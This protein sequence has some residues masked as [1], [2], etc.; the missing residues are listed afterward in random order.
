MRLICPECAAQYE[1]DVS[2]IP[3]GGR[4]VQCSNCGHTWWQ[5][6]DGIRE[7]EPKPEQAP[8]DDIAEDVAEPAPQQAPEAAEERSSKPVMHENLEAED[9]AATLAA[10]AGAQGTVPDHPDRSLDDAVLDVLREEAHRET[11]A[12]VAEDPDRKSEA[13]DSKAEET[14]E[15]DVDPQKVKFTAEGVPIAPRPHN[16]KL[17]PDIDE[18]NSTLDGQDAAEDDDDDGDTEDGLARPKKRGFRVG[19]VLMLTVAAALVAVYVYAD[20]IGEKVPS[21]K[22]TLATF[23]EKV[24][25]GRIWLDQAALRASEAIKD[26]T[27]GE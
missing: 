2:V 16:S 15:S 4:D 3:E 13:D 9:V 14:A 27:S 23:T 6:R 21:L 18:I 22:P 19:F 10:T 8:A 5:L 24:D 11:E 1:V 7:I 17:L 12:R 26:M 25:E 20:M